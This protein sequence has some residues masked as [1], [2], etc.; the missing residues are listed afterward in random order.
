[1]LQANN[2]GPGS[3]VLPGDMAAVRKLA[4]DGKININVIS[5]AP[6]KAQ[7]SAQSAIAAMHAKQAQLQRSASAASDGTASSQEA[8]DQKEEAGG[9]PDDTTHLFVATETYKGLV[10]KLLSKLLKARSDVKKQMKKEKDKFKYGML[11][12]KQL[13]IKVRVDR[14]VDKLLA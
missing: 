11:N 10:P 1:M 12:S 2:I 7:G 3:Y 14:F 13:A 9:K 4:A 6:D 8:D 5:T